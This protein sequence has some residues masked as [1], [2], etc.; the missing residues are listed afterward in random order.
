[1][2][3]KIP[4]SVFN[5]IL[6]FPMKT[7]RESTLPLKGYMLPLINEVLNVKAIKYTLAGVYGGYC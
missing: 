6:E 2:L 5:E 3:L 1:M 7:E 4:P